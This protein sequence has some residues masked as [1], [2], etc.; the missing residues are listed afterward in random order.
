MPEYSSVY[1][2]SESSTTENSFE[3]A[4]DGSG[5]YKLDNL[6]IAPIETEWHHLAI[7][8]DGN[9]F[10]AFI[11]GQEVLAEE[12]AYSFKFDLFRIGTNR[13]DDKGFEG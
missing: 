13:N 9:T 2:S 1:S 10:K 4:S 11:N 8:Y 7:S 12:L 3:I 6:I 5:N